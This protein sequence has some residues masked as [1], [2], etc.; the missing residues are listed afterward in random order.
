MKTRHLETDQWLNRKEWCLGSGSDSC[1]MTGKIDRNMV[2]STLV[3]ALRLC[4][5]RTAH[6]MSRGIALLFHDHGSRMGS[7]ISVTPQPLFTP[8]KDPVPIVQEARWVP[9]PVWTSA[10]N[11]APTGIKSPDRPVRSQSLYRLRYPL[12]VVLAKFRKATIISVILVGRGRAISTNS[13]VTTT[14]QR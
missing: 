5:G 10:E 7:G 6:R 13:T 2:K 3:Q 1:H 8:E 9:G 11:L 12:L 4:T 14:L